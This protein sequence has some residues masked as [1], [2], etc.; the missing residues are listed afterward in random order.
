M[1]AR[2]FYLPVLGLF[3]ARQ[4]SLWL[5]AAFAQAL[6]G[7]VGWPGVT[8]L[9]RNALCRV[10]SYVLASITGICVNVSL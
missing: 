4:R 2:P 7:S 9:Q 5:P 8:R 3:R 10:W 1:K 6:A